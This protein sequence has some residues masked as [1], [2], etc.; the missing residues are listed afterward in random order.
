MR[1]RES[2]NQVRKPLKVRTT[3]D[4]TH[5]ECT[6]RTQRKESLMGNRFRR[7]SLAAV[8]VVGG[9][10]W[11]LAGQ[12]HSHPHLAGPWVSPLPDRGS[13]TF[14]FATGAYLGSGI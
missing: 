8:L 7:R 12:A 11:G 4:D 1:S 5:M 13:M 9:L 14:D 6:R 3:A 2:L 10:L